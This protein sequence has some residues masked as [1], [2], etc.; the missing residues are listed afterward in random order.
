MSK[1]V[2]GER[3]ELRNHA[4]TIVDAIAL[5]EPGEYTIIGPDGTEIASLST[6]RTQPIRE[7]TSYA[8][9]LRLLYSEGTEMSTTEIINRITYANSDATIYMACRDLYWG[10]LVDKTD[11]DPL[12]IELNDAGRAMIAEL[13]NVNAKQ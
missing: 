3:I 4:S 5:D 12:T 6:E 8:L 10:C 7:G 9:V 2:K 11:D 13:N 1:N